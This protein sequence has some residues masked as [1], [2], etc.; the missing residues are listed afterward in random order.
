MTTHA[1]PSVLPDDAIGAVRTAAIATSVVG[2]AL[3]IA[4]LVAPGLSLFLV[5]VLFGAALIVTGLFRL[6]I[7]FAVTA[8]SYWVR[9]G[10][11]LLG[12]VVLAV[13]VVGV[14]NPA[15]SLEFLGIM[16]GVGW[17]LSGMHDIVGWRAPSTLLLPRWTVLVGGA[18]SVAAG[19]AMIVLPAVFSL[20]VI[21]WVLAVLL[22]AVSVATL[23]NLPTKR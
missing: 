14:L 13:G 11:A 5:G 2:I 21:L 6:F 17:I 19:I 22:I 7:A 12:V 4:V 1:T 15:R 20:S 10:L 18:L 9:M 16:I 8:A 23:C 3:G